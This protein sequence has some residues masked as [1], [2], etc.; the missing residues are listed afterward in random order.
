LDKENRFFPYILPTAIFISIF[1]GCLALGPLLF[2]V[3]GDLGR[4]LTLGNY[5]LTSGK[6]PVADIFSQ[7]LTGQP[8]SP[9]EWL[10]AVIFRLFYNLDRLPGVVLFTSAFLASVFWL[11]TYRVYRISRSTTITLIL[12]V[13]GLAGSR[14]HWLARPHI[15]TYLFLFLWIDLLRWRGPRWQRWLM[16]VLL[17][18]VWVNTH[19]AFVTGYVVL[20][21]FLAG[22]VLDGLRSRDWR[23]VLADLRADL[24][25]FIS[26]LLLSLANPS[27]KEIWTTILG[28]LG[29][30]YLVSHTAEYMPPVLYSAGVA[31][32]SILVILGLVLIVLR[33]KQMSFTDMLLIAAFAVFGATSGRNIPLYILIAL[34]ILAEGFTALLPRWK[35]KLDDQFREPDGDPDPRPAGERARNLALTALVVMILGWAGLRIAPAWRDRLAYSPEKFP[36]QAVDWLAAH[37][38][39]GHIFNDF[40]WGGYLLYRLWPEQQVFIDGQTDFY[41]EALTRDYETISGAYTGWQAAVDKH[42][43]DWMIIPVNSPLTTALSTPDSG[44]SVLYKD[45]TA[46]IFRR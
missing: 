8:L 12:V 5:I 37:P 41:G 21:I 2:N 11:I 1:A 4:H 10:A 36:V 22:R 31:P 42:S 6:I 45:Q 24:I 30:S 13:V 43:I 44:W 20:G 27:G 23:A 14:I 16:G 33:F 19:G 25:L 29:S 46:V 17:Y 18:V 3:D 39:D 15:F 34:P 26:V 38:Q 40:M 35:M 9:H 28:F 32:F 7:T